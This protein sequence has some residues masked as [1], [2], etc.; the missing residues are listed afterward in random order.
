MLTLGEEVIIPINGKPIYA[1]FTPFV[2]CTMLRHHLQQ[3]PQ[4]HSTNGWAPH[5]VNVPHPIQQWR[6]DSNELWQG[7]E[8]TQLM[9]VVDTLA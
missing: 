5:S 2:P 4:I 8:R 6:D 7:K 3:P 1:I 9:L